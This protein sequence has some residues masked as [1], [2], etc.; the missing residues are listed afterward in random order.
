MFILGRDVIPQEPTQ[1]DDSKEH[2]EPIKMPELKTIYHILW[3]KGSITATIVF[4]ARIS[5]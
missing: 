4:R 1:F 2:K 3:V 5:I